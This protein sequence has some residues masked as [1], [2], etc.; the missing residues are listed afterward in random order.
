MPAA[1][2]RTA[3][4]AKS[5][6]WAAVVVARGR[7]LPGERGQQRRL[8][9]RAPRGR[10]PARLREQ[11]PPRLHHRAHHLDVERPGPC[12]QVHEHVGAAVQ[13]PVEH[14]H[15]VA[16]ADLDEPELLEALHALADGG[17]VDAE[18]CRQRALRRQP[19][20]RGEAAREHVGDE[21]VEDLVGQRGAGEGVGHETIVPVFRTIQTCGK[22]GICIARDAVRP[23]PYRA[24]RPV[25]FGGEESDNTCPSASSIRRMR[26]AS[27]SS[28]SVARRAGSCWASS[29]AR[30]STRSPSR[31]SRPTTPRR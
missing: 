16:V 20:A 27:W 11:Q 17:H 12:D 5:R 19:L 31:S 3:N 4:Q 6:C 22:S 25:R 15:R 8:R 26:S 7:E 10:Q 14:P 18:L 28:R 30:G 2:I 13:P 1:S 21:P 23:A 9:L 29:S 24:S